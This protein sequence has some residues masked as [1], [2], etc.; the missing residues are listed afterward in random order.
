MGSLLGMGGDSGGAGPIRTTSGGTIEIVPDSR[1]NALIIQAS[2]TD[3]DTIEN[4]LKVLDQRSSPEDVSTTAQPRLIPVFNAS[5]E[6]RS[7]PKGFSI[8]MRRQPEPCEVISSF[9]RF[10]MM[11][12]YKFGA[13]ER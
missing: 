4:L 8:M 2:P 10:V 11:A 1:L 7:I 12:G 3:L 9:P 5:A 13:T 6:S